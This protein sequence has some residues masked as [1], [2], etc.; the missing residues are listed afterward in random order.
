MLLRIVDEALGR[1]QRAA[2]A[3]ATAAAVPLPGAEALRTA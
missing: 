1:A 2:A 3:A